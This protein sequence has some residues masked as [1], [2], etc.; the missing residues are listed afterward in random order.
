MESIASSH[1]T[2][3]PGSTSPCEALR[4]RVGIL[5]RRGTDDQVRPLADGLVSLALERL[6]QLN[7]LVA[8]ATLD[9]NL[10]RGV[11]LLGDL[12]FPGLVRGLVVPALLVCE[13]VL[14]AARR[15]DDGVM[16]ELGE[17]H[18]MGV[19]RLLR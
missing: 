10:P 9:P 13:P 2:A 11:A 19:L 3:P 5:A 18:G 4:E 14:D 8:R 17:D 7:R 16:L 1:T 12:F 6:L 15:G